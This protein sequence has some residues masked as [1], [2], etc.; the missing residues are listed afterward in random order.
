MLGVSWVTVVILATQVCAPHLLCPSS[1]GPLRQP[2]LHP[3]PPLPCPCTSP[4][5]S[6][7]SDSEDDS[8]TLEE[9]RDRPCRGDA[10]G[11]LDSSSLSPPGTCS[12]AGGHRAHDAFEGP[13]PHAALPWVY[14][15]FM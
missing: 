5:E 15:A 1:P 11:V 8:W 6:P 3:A 2:H 7:S 10:D 12:V 14:R 13:A 9:G 4:R